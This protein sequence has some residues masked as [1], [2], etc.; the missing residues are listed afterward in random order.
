[1]LREEAASPSRRLLTRRY[2]ELA[3][4]RVRGA[5]AAARGDERGVAFYRDEAAR[6]RRNVTGILRPRVYL[7]AKSVAAEVAEWVR[8]ANAEAAAEAALIAEYEARL[9]I[10]PVA[11][12]SASSEGPKPATALSSLTLSD[13]P[14][15]RAPL[16]Y[17]AP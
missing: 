17:C 13:A 6:A 14:F 1:M 5:S 9:I 10:P 12:F 7:P 4:C 16:A 8:L 2:A 15:P 3:Y 11:D